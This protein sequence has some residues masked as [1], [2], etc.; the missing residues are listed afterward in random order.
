MAKVDEL[1]NQIFTFPPRVLVNVNIIESG[2]SPWYDFRK[3]PKVLHADVAEAIERGFDCGGY[4]AGGCARWLRSIGGKPTALLRGTYVHEGGD[5][6]LWFRSFEGWRQFVNSYATDDDTTWP[7]VKL[8][9]GKLAANFTFPTPRRNKNPSAYI[10]APTV[11]AI[12]CI[13]GEP[14]T[15]VRSFDFHNSM[16][17]FDR[18]K[19]WVVEDWDDAE[20]KKE[21]RVAWWGSRSVAYRVGKYMSKYGYRKLVNASEAMFEQL[22]SGTDLMTEKQKQTS[23]Y[24]WMDIVRY[25]ICD[26]EMKLMIL[27][28]TVKGIETDDL[29]KLTKNSVE[30]VYIGMY[31]VAINS[32]L[33]RQEEAYRKKVNGVHREE[34]ADPEDFNAEEY[35]WAIG[36]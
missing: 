21:L 3:D 28:S 32:L 29:F 30:R 19:T 20:A 10:E 23:R 24:K 8:S 14:E 6:D 7:K 31:E 12:C 4:V 15:I 26:L 5:I 11:Q 13:T 16:V 22:V 17:A 36:A 25:D 18:H 9:E 35:C 27:A 1:A 34:Y 2:A 33:A